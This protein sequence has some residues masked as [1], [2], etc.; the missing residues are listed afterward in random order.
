LLGRL[1]AGEDKTFGV[2]TFN[3]PQQ[4]LVEDLLEAARR[5]HPEIER[6]FSEDS[7]EPVFVKNL[8]NVQGDERDVIL[9]S[10]CYGP[11][12]DGKF[13]HN[14]G[15]LNLEGG[16]RRLNVAVTR[17]REQLRIF[18]SLRAGQIDSA[19][20][21]A[22]GASDLKLFLDYAERGSVVLSGQHTASQSSEQLSPLE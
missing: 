16:E 3:Q 12:P 22:K 17:A 1:L 10:I 11:D 7:L 5:E 2:V 8:E 15:P 18:A 13:V 6:Y 20:A 4:M 21:T 19:K 9:F 14:F